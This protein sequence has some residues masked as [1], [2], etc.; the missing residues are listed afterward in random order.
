MKKFILLIGILA[1]II[2]S[3]SV[4]A[5]GCVEASSDDG[6]QIVGYI[7]PQ[8]NYYMSGTNENGDPVDPSTFFFKRARIGV[9]GS[10]PYDVSYYFMADYVRKN[11]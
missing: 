1:I 8:F 10:I 7:Q 6:P 9:V 5:Q 2:S 4:Y 11:S 3:G